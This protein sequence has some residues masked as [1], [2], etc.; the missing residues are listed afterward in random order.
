MREPFEMVTA[1]L[2][3]NMVQL[4]KE[5]TYFVTNLFLEILE[6]VLLGLSALRAPTVHSG[7]MKSVC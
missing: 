7:A 2:M 3:Q 1:L 6:A 4:R 5:N